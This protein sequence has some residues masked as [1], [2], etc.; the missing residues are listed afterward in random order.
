[1]VYRSLSIWVFLWL[2]FWFFYLSHIF[3][4]DWSK[5]V[6][7]E[8]ELVQINLPNKS[9]PTKLSKWRSTTSIAKRENVDVCVDQLSP[10]FC[11]KSSDEFKKW[12][13]LLK[14]SNDGW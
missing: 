10:E 11:Y 12:I 8:G 7:K 9:I 1:M 6:L 3:V 14:L 4:L 2:K 5:K 13:N